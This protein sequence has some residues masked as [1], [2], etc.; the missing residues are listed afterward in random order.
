ML[1]FGSVWIS[2]NSDPKYGGGLL[3]A[4]PAI[5]GFFWLIGALFT[6]WWKK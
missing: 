1:L 4:M 3:E 5:I 6:V 2:S